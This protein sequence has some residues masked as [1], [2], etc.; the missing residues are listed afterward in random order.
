MVVG[1]LR[2]LSTQVRSAPTGTT[3][4]A[5]GNEH[6]CEYVGHQ[7]KRL[8][9]TVRKHVGRQHVPGANLTL[10]FSKTTSKLPFPDEEAQMN[11]NFISFALSTIGSCPRL[12]GEHVQN[13]LQKL[14]A[15]I[16]R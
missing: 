15:R 1:N 7:S 6:G 12:L 5:C 4:G 14:T 10:F 2:W 3:T 11:L 9:C 13:I 8:Q 16:V